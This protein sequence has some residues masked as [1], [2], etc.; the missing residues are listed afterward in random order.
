MSPSL[1]KAWDTQTSRRSRQSR[2][3]E[4]PDG[5]GTEGS[6]VCQRQGASSLLRSQNAPGDRPALSGL[7]RPPG[8]FPTR[9]CILQTHLYPPKSAPHRQ[10]PWQSRDRLEKNFLTAALKRGHGQSAED[11]S[12]TTEDYA[13]EQATANGCALTSQVR[14]FK[15]SCWDVPGGPVVKTWRFHFRGQGL[16]P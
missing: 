15:P 5:V 14:S 2:G 12:C 9:R 7:P 4:R 10:L 6:Q 3:R 1:P 16:D 11:H 8:A 13:L